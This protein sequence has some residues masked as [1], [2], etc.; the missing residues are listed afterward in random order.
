MT[1]PW[2]DLP[3]PYA[4][5]KR[6]DADRAKEAADTIRDA[7]AETS[8]L[9]RAFKSAEDDVRRADYNPSGHLTAAGVNEAKNKALEK[10]RADY[11]AQLTEHREEIDSAAKRLTDYAAAEPLPDGDETA[12]RGAHWRRAE[13]LLD[14][15]VHPSQII[16]DATD[17]EVLL[18]LRD[19]LPTRLAVESAKRNGGG[20]NSL[21]DRGSGDA[22]ASEVLRA[23]D[24]RLADLSHPAATF[25]IARNAL[26]TAE[27]VT[28]H[29][30]DAQDVIDGGSMLTY[31][32]AAAGTTGR[33]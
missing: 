23:I 17:P 16:R 15:G 11:S 10:L 12:R 22:E 18:A 14:A 26:V 19:E 6:S 3:L 1:N 33:Y 28:R 21:T 29:V 25:A 27:A 7:M 32:I 9:V 30:T 8:K 4:K 13:A 2:A 31:A 20:F 24:G 5:P